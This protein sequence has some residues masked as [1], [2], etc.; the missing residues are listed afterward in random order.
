[1]KKARNVV[2]AVAVGLLFAT[3]IMMLVL[4]WTGVWVEEEAGFLDD[5]PG[6]ESTPVHVSGEDPEAMAAAIDAINE[7][8]DCPML[9]H[10][11]TAPSIIVLFGVPHE[12]GWMDTAGDAEYGRDDTRSSPTYCRVRIG[13]TGTS[14]LTHM[15]LV[16]ELLHCLGLAHD[17]FDAS[18]MRE[19]Q[20]RDI[21]LANQVRV[22]DHDRALLNERYCR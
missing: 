3:V 15:V 7:Q 13:N 1:M 11:H 6:W 19:R 2:M 8:L 12:P 21:S 5:H 20:R 9:V 17:D 10:D 18:V 22:T 16:H 4:R 14:D